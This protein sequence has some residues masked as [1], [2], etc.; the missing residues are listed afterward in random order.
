MNLLLLPS[1]VKLEKKLRDSTLKI[2]EDPEVWIT[3]LEDISGR[4]EEMG[5]EILTK[6]FKINVLNN[7]VQ[8]SIYR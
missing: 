8:I 7:L 6:Q 2:D 3:Q 4:F 5:L 1:L